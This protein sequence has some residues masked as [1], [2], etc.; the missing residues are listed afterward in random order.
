MSGVEIRTSHLVARLALDWIGRDQRPRLIVRDELELIWA[1]KAAEEA[2]RQRRDIELREGVITATNKAHQ[3]ELWEFVRAATHESTLLALPSEELDGHLMLQAQRVSEASR[4]KHVAMQFYWSDLRRIEFADF[5]RIFGLTQAE[6]QVL[7]RLLQGK[8]A[9]EVS[10]EKKV[11]IET[12][13]YQI[14]QIYDKLNVSSRE[15][16]FHKVYPYII[17]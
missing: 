12:V 4:A 10:S 9:D 17:L 1:N 5:R 8:T 16:L 2:L 6:Q 3:D 7:L 13:R 15:G 11:S 14:R